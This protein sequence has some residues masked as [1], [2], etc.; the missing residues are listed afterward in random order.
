MC[1]AR[2]KR[3]PGMQSKRAL[4]WWHHITPRN[5]ASAPPQ[6][7]HGVGRRRGAGDC[8]KPRDSNDGKWKTPV[9]LLAG[10]VVESVLCFI[11]LRDRPCLRTLFV[12]GRGSR[13]TGCCGQPPVWGSGTPGRGEGGW[14]ESAGASPTGVLDR[15]W[16]LQVSTTAIGESNPS[17]RLGHGVRGAHASRPERSNRS[18]G[19][20]TS[21]WVKRW[22]TYPSRRPL[23]PLFY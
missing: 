7:L 3:N 22:S 15:S 21:R 23:G 19:F 14:E 2:P 10:L 12:T 4:V 17:V 11:S 6:D 16:L 1:F 5:P 9:V 8:A 20:E 18:E 13:W